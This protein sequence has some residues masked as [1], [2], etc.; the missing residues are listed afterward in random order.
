MDVYECIALGLILSLSAVSRF[1]LMKVVIGSAQCIKPWR[2]VI[3]YDFQRHRQL[4]NN[5]FARMIPPND[6][7]SSLLPLNF[8]KQVQLLQ[9]TSLEV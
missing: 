2:K 7:K 9:M 3:M 1:P 5:K 6:W 8:N 4:G